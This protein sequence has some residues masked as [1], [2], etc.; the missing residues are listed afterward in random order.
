SV[1]PGTAVSWQGD[2]T[3]LP[4]AREVVGGYPMLLQRS[5]AVHHD[6]AGLRTTF[7]DRRHPRAAIGID[8]KGRI[9]IVAVDGRRPGYSDGMTLQELGDFLIAHGITDALNLDGGGSTTLV[10]GGRIVNRPTDANGE[11]AV[12]NAL[13]VI[14]QSQANGACNRKR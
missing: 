8:G 13:L 4:R 7:S 12:S 14:D 1:R 11:R 3:P 9:H 6:E 2:L 10:V 5:N